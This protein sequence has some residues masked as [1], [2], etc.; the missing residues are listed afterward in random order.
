MS[1]SQ[2]PVDRDEL[3]RQLSAASKQLQDLPAEAFAERADLRHLQNALR[4][5]LAPPGDGRTA[6]SLRTEIDQLETR[7]DRLHRNRPNVAA[8]GGSGEGGGDGIAEAQVLAGDYDRGQDRT[9][10]EAR[11]AELRRALAEL[12]A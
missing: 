1:D 8:S 9:A 5:A 2:A 12:D 7:L 6:A 4:A 3:L 10:I 11:I